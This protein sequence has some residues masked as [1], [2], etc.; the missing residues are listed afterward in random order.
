MYFAINHKI[1]N[2]LEFWNTIKK[3]KKIKN[4]EAEKNYL[5]IWI[6]VE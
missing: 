5:K 4:E 1:H 2:Q 6:L 3:I